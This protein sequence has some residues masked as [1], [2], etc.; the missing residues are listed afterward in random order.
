ML[1][2]YLFGVGLLGFDCEG[3]DRFVLMDLVGGFEFACA[4]GSLFAVVSGC[5]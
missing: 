4:L 5:G 1:G 2:A 3:G